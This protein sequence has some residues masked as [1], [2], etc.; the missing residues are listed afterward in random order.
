MWLL[1]VKG[2]GEL[3]LGEENELEREKQG[4]RSAREEELEGASSEAATSE[5]AMEL[6]AVEAMEP[7]P[8]GNYAF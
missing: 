2:H 7:D 3:D 8:S 6:Q 5:N 4:A 1:K